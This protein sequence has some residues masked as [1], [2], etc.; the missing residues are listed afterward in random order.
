M[1][2]KYFTVNIVW[3]L[4]LMI[5]QALLRQKT[6]PIKI[7]AKWCTDRAFSYIRCWTVSWVGLSRTFCFMYFFTD[8]MNP[9][10]FFFLLTS[11]Y[12]PQQVPKCHS[13]S[14]PEGVFHL[15]LSSSIFAC[16]IGV[17]T[18]L[19]LLIALH[20]LLSPFRLEIASENAKRK[21]KKAHQSTQ[22]E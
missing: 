11:K 4:Y 17:M 6:P 3:K 18:N 14:Q 1:G 21:K 20:W 10:F 5:D 13:Q 9:L 19:H 2:V 16:L 15:F 8:M 12:K 22:W 7:I